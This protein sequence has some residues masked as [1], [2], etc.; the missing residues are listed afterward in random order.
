[1]QILIIKP[2]SLGDVVHALPTVNLIRRKYPQAHISWLVNDTLT[3]LLQRCPIIDEII[4]FERR[5]FGSL[6]QLPHFR[7]FLAT[8]KGRHFDI[9]IDLQGLLRSGIISWATRAPRRI[10]LSDAREGARFFYNEIVRVPRAH[11]V[12]RYLLAAQHLGCDSTPVEFPLG[13]SRSV[14]SEGLIG[15][16]PSARWATKLWGNDKFAELIRR[17]PS[18]RV[19]LTGSAVEREQIDKI[20][21]GRRNLV[22]QTDL[23]QL[24]ELYRRCQVVVTNDSG[25]MH[26][27]AA[28]GTPVVAIFGPTDPALTGPYGDRH[29]VLRAGVRCSPCFKDSCANKVHMECMKLI[30]VEQVLEAAKCFLA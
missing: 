11:A 7:N 20:A 25:P 22:G 17:L 8:L 12:D 1:M 10:G 27:A 14:T 13:G 28:V 23:F 5:R 29:V 19:V 30:T 2:S 6:T 4:P 18:E 26:L 16:N 15:V 3:S 9:A 24:A 21:Q